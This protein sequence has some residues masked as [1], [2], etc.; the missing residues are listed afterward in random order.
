MCSM[1]IGAALFLPVGGSLLPPRRVRRGPRNIPLLEI[2]VPC[3]LRLDPVG[4]TA[5]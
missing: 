2:S 3:L 4:I 5:G 1:L